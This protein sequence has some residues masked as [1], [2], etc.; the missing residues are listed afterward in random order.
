MDSFHLSWNNNNNNNNNNKHI[1]DIIDNKDI[2]I[3]YG[4]YGTGN[5]IMIV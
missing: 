4:G 3:I 2:F 1:V 5:I